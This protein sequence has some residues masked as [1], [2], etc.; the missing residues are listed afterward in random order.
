VVDVLYLAARPAREDIVIWE[1]IIKD[2]SF[3]AIADPH[4]VIS[5]FSDHFG[6]WYGGGGIMPPLFFPYA[7]P[8][9]FFKLIEE[10]QLKHFRPLYSSVVLKI[11]SYANETG[12]HYS[13][14][15]PTPPQFPI[16]DDI[17]SHEYSVSRNTSLLQ[18]LENIW[19][20]ADCPRT[21]TSIDASQFLH[22]IC[23]DFPEDIDKAACCML[24]IDAKIDYCSICYL[25]FYWNESR[26]HWGA[27]LLWSATD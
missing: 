12:N 5:R 18:T 20:G 1:R 8:S 14:S 19:L 7:M 11:L 10:D 23:P 16:V 27:F 21:F 15:R 17:T 2:A 4:Q 24:Y 25:I 22:A 9:F 26:T 3:P 13:R 6:C